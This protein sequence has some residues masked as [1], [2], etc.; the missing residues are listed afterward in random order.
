LPANEVETIDA[1]KPD[2]VIAAE[3]L[4]LINRIL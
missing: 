3:A 2:E 1:T 4:A